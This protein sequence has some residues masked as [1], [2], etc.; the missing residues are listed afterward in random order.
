MP[1]AFEG[2]TI[3]KHLV[4]EGHAESLLLEQ[5]LEAEDQDVVVRLLINVHND[6]CFQ[7]LDRV[8]RA[9]QH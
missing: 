3:L 7:M 1:V 2:A 8:G 4:L 6:P 9:D 5:S